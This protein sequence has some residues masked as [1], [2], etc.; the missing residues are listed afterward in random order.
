LIIVPPLFD[1]LFGGGY[2]LK[3]IFTGDEF[4]ETLKNFFNPFYDLSPLGITYGMRLEITLALL[5]ILIYVL[6]KDG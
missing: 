2:K 3:Y 4:W 6:P 5:G 1:S